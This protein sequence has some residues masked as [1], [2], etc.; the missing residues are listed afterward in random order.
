[1]FAETEFIILDCC[2]RIKS[3][4]RRLVV[5]SSNVPASSPP[6]QISEGHIAVRANLGDGAHSLRLPGHRVDV[7]QWVLVSLGRHDNKFILRLEQGGG[8]REV[9]AELGRR[10][11]IVVHPTSLTVGNSPNVG[12]RA[13]FQGEILLSSAL[14][15]QRYFL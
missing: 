14:R 13:D 9:Q 10:R 4:I 2:S 3:D 6:T 11:E 7:G 15:C 8:S 5:S 12:D 1:M